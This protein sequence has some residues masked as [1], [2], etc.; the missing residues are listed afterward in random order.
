ML[1]AKMSTPQVGIQEANARGSYLSLA[2]TITAKFKCCNT[3]AATSPTHD[4]PQVEARSTATTGGIH[5]I[6]EEPEE[7][8]P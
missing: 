4:R 7:T 3:N 8:P 5:P 2:T 6:P 1:Q